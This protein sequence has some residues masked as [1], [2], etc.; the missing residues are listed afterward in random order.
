MAYSPCSSPE[1]PEMGFSW[2]MALVVVITVVSSFIN[3]SHILSDEQVLGF[4]LII[5]YIEE[6][7]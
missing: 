1:K 2:K 4:I 5:L 3:R 6:V 7:K